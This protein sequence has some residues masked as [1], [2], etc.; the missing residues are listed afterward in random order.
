MLGDAT[1]AGRMASLQGFN[2]YGY[3]NQFPEFYVEMGKLIKAG[4][5]KWQQTVVEGIEKA[6]EALMG[7]FSGQ[8]T[9]KMLVKI[10]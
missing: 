1:L 2:C 7:L 9:G 5:M 8:N 3:L 4:K 10:G 6:P